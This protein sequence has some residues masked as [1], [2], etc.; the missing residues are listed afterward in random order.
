[1]AGRYEEAAK[2]ARRSLQHRPDSALAG[3]TLAAS[4]AQAGLLDEATEAI[5]ATYPT[6]ARPSLSRVRQILG[7]ADPEVAERFLEGLRRAGLE[8][9]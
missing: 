2:W 5:D 1:V 4:L 6:G 7:H 8:G 3:A 9:E